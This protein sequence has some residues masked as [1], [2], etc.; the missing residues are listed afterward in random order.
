MV[1]KYPKKYIVTRIVFDNHYYVVIYHKE[2]LMHIERWQA[3]KFFNRKVYNKYRKDLRIETKK[4]LAEVEKPE[5]QDI[6]EFSKKLRRIIKARTKDAPRG[7]IWVML[8]KIG[9]YE[10]Y[11][12]KHGKHTRYEHEYFEIAGKNVEDLISCLNQRL[13]KYHSSNLLMD[14]NIVELIEFNQKSPEEMFFNLTDAQKLHDIGEYAEIKKLDDFQDPDFK[15]NLD[16]TIEKGKHRRKIKKQKKK[17]NNW[18]NIAK[19]KIGLK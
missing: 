8:V 15:D 17:S 18:G 13:D 12:D 5:K 3:K 7:F 2:T 4:H 6:E 10:D 19:G 11:Y 14:R 16:K 9:H 1:N